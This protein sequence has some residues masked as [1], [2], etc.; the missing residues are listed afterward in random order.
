MREEATP[1]ASSARAPRAAVSA[2]TPAA[3]L[4]HHGEGQAM[5]QAKNGEAFWV[6]GWVAGW[7]VAGWL[8]GWLWAR[9]REAVGCGSRRCAG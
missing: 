1:A 2:P 3:S 8:A 5:L 6:A 9:R 4:R 7:V